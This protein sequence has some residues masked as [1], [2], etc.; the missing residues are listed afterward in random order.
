MLRAIT[1]KAGRKIAMTTVSQIELSLSG[2]EYEP[3]RLWDIDGVQHQAPDSPD[4]IEEE[5]GQDP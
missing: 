1:A 4:P 2:D 5:P 3:L